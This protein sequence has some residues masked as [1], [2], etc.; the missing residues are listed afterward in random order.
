MRPGGPGGRGGLGGYGGRAGPPVRGPSGGRGGGM[1]SQGLLAEM[2]MKQEQRDK[3]KRLKEELDSMSSSGHCDLGRATRIRVELAAIESFLIRTD[4]VNAL[5]QA[6]PQ[7][8]NVREDISESTNLY[9]GSLSPVWTEELVAREFGRFGEVVSIKIMYPRTDAQRY[10][11][12]NSGFVQF[13]ARG[14]AEA[15]RRALNGKEYFGMALRIDWGRAVQSSANPWGDMPLRPHLGENATGMGGGAGAVMGAGMTAPGAMVDPSGGERRTRWNL[16]QTI[17]VRAPTDEATKRLID[18]TAAFVATDG[19]E[20]EQLLFER[21]RGNPR[22]SFL[23]PPQEGPEDPLHTYYRW[24]VFSLVQGDT[25]EIW[26]TEPFQVYDG[27]PLWQAPPCDAS[28]VAQAD[29]SAANAV[30]AVVAAAGV[31]AGRRPGGSSG[32]AEL[33]PEELRTLNDFIAGLSLTQESICKAMVFCLDTAAASQLIARRICGSITEAQEGLTTSQL[34]ARLCLL[35]DVLYN[36][37]CTRPGASMYRRF[38]QELLPDVMERV[39]EV[40]DGVSLLAGNSLRERV[41]KLLHIWSEWSSFSPQFTRGL[42]SVICGETPANLAK[43]SLNEAVLSKQAQ[44]ATNDDTSLERAC[45]LRGLS[46]RGERKRWLE[47]LATFETYWTQASESE[48][49]ANAAAASK[50]AKVERDPLPP[51]DPELDGE[52]ATEKELEEAREADTAS[53][54][55]REGANRLSALLVLCEGLEALRAHPVLSVNP[56]AERDAAASP[57]MCHSSKSD[58]VFVDQA[59]D[60]ADMMDG[61]GGDS[62]LG[63]SMSSSSSSSAPAEAAGGADREQKAAAAAAAAAEELR[64]KRLRR[65]ESEVAKFRASLESAR[66]DAEVVGMKCDRKRMELMEA[67][68]REEV[69][70]VRQQQSQQPKAP[71]KQPPKAPQ[72]QQQAQQPQQASAQRAATSAPESDPAPQRTRLTSETPSPSASP[73]RMAL[74]SPS[75][76]RPPKKAKAQSTKGSSKAAEAAVAGEKEEQRE[77]R[78][79]RKAK[80]LR[81]ARKAEL[82]AEIAALKKEREEA[83]DSAAAT[84]SAKEKDSKDSKRKGKESAKARAS[85]SRSEPRK[86]SKRARDRSP[87]PRDRGSAGERDRDR[88]RRSAADKRS[89]SRSAGRRRR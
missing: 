32:L 83:K 19:F 78:E 79:A 18:C 28:P 58:D 29:A 7:Y 61:E 52:A 89:R 25:H 70:D 69:N 14:A 46:T 33:T 48:A 23:R 59:G 56:F 66:V 35:S 17:V 15:A 81:D 41:V 42:E 10:R 84:S 2:K 53:A 64:K 55:G 38:F 75:P 44:W 51:P 20:L 22:F 40:V 82:Q 74:T 49:Q 77:A 68:A 63:P 39:R 45:R 31:P 65:V 3:R 54:E 16:A 12:M 36:S 26:R 87:A 21:E 27:G 76:T 1:Q 9:V 80:E 73:P 72:P 43:A 62:V 71:Q 24:R 4:G 88:D 47:R 37:H 67:V 8:N 5:Q 30:A 34:S 11:A 60:E 85:R 86:E 57:G 50:D 13:K 6:E